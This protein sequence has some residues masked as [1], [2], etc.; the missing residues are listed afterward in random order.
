MSYSDQELKAA[1]D[2]VFKQYDTDKSDT[3]EGEEVR[4]LINGALVHLKAQK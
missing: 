2:A 3:L 4:K 1:V